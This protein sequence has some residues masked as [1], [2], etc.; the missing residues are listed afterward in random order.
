[1]I[2]CGFTTIVV[3]PDLVLS[4]VEVAVIVTCSDTFPELGAVNKPVVEIEPALADHVTPELKLP[5]PVTE[6]E[7]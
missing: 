4:W 5:V 6:A 1:M 7:H 2:D 3:V